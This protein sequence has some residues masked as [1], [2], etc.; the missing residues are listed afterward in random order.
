[1]ERTKLIFMVILGILG[2]II[3]LQN[4]E[5]VETRILFATLKMP[6]AILL[7]GTFAIGFAVGVLVPLILIKKDRRIEGQREE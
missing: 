4:T 2:L 5:P 6:R 7:F 1:M 3:I